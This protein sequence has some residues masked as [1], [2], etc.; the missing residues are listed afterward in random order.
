M[1]L[2]PGV[3]RHPSLPRTLIVDTRVARFYPLELFHLVGFRKRRKHGAILLVS[4]R[5]F[6][7]RAP[8]RRAAGT[9]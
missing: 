3:R 8:K 1:W 5:P 4:R 7:L 9:A 2:L 6:D